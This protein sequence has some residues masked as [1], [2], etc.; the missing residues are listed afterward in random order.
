MYIFCIPVDIELI[1]LHEIGVW[2]TF[3][4]RKGKID[5]I[6][7]WYRCKTREIPISGKMAKSQFRLRNCNFS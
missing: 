1:K 2:G 4:W 3:W 7:S 5:A 6:E